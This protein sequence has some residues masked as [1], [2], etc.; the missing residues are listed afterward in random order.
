MKVVTV[1]FQ[2]GEPFVPIYVQELIRT[3]QKAATTYWA[4]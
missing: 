4:T 2:S 3:W 1:T